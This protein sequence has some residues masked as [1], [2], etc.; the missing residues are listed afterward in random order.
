MDTSTIS[1]ACIWINLYRVIQFPRMLRWLF[2]EDKVGDERLVWNGFRG[3]QGIV[4]WIQ[5][6]SAKQP[7]MKFIISNQFVRQTKQCS[8][9]AD[10][11]C[12][13]LGCDAQHFINRA[14]MRNRIMARWKINC[15]WSL[16][17]MHLK[18]YS[19]DSR[20]RKNSHRH[21]DPIA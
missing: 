20:I 6:N 13:S 4:P 11:N 18:S 16:N 21:K 19:Q 14:E 3:R 8:F 9:S 2:Q 10:P 15:N 12:N 5:I 17:R 1:V 7:H